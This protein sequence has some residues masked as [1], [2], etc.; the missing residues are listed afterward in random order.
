MNQGVWHQDCTM[1]IATRKYHIA[2]H[3]RGVG[4]GDSDAGWL[5]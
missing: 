1:I 4:L 5:G 2:K 3:Y